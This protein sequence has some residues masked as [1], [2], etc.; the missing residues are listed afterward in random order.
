M[1]ID[2]H[3]HILPGVDHGSK[4][5][6]NSLKQLRILKKFGVDTVVATSHFYPNA[7]TVAEFLA[8]RDVGARELLS[9]APD[10]RP[11]I[12]L[13]AEVFLC[14]GLHKMPG[15]EKLC[16]EGTNCLLL[17]MPVT[18]WYDG[19]METVEEIMRQG[20]TVVLAH[21]DRYEEYWKRLEV[22]ISMGARVQINAQALGKSGLGKRLLPYFEQGHVVALGSDLHGSCPAPVRLLKKLSR[23]LDGFDEV[24]ARSESLLAT[25]KKY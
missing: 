13:G 4:D 6:S 18:I 7:H 16:I 19:M 9:S 1:I 17:E 10:E 14:E 3:S 2:F 15:L 5:L 21:I 22:L 11:A 25:A 8:L 24:M 23:R 12:C 20:F